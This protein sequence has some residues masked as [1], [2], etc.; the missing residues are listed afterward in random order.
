MGGTFSPWTEVIINRAKRG[1]APLES[2]IADAIAVVPPGRGYRHRMKDIERVRAANG[3]VA[4]YFPDA[5][6]KKSQRMVGGQRAVVWDSMAGLIERGKIEVFQEDGVQMLRPGPSL[7]KTAL[8]ATK[9]TP[10]AI[11]LMQAVEA[12]PMPEAALFEI[13]KESVSEERALEA[14][15]HRSRYRRAPHTSRPG[16]PH[17]Y[18]REE[19]IE[20]GRRQLYIAAL[21]SFAKTKRLRRFEVKGVKMVG[22]GSNWTLHGAG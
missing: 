11:R 2:V 13:V 14:R 5:E 15:E 20:T 7:A 3:A 18:T 12:G 8:P 19:K 16:R 17:E 9:M 10:L 1:P 4:R 22:P 6:A 21:N